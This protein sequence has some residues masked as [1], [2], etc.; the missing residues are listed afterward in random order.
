MVS[1]TW[2]ANAIGTSNVEATVDPDGTVDECVETNNDFSAQFSVYPLPPHNIAVYKT[3]I[4]SSVK[5]TKFVGANA[6]DGKMNTQWTSASSDPQ[7]IIVDLGAK[8]YI[9]DVLLYW[10]WAYAIEYYI[11]ISDDTLLWT[12]I[13]HVTNGDGGEDKIS[14]DASAR[15]V[16]MFGIQRISQQSGYSLYEFEIYGATPTG[17]NTKKFFLYNNYPNP[18]NLSTKI[19]FT[20][21]EK[22]RAT[23]KVYNI[24]GQEIAILF[25]QTVEAQKI[26]RVSFSG[27]GLPSGI[28]F[29]I[30]ESGKQRAVK[31]MV[32][33]K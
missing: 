2:T 31:P 27:S 33:M 26:H 30:L 32:L 1:V 20:L 3:A 29:A 9:S 5:G 24:L 15:F 10:G 19:E 22:D 14:V 21:V 12:D 13:Q 28:Y 11:Q 18:F 16:R 17:I 23:L 25:D 4:V 6:V 7:I 8:E